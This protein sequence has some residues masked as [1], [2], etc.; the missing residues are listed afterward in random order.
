M[1]IVDISGYTRFIKHRIISLLHAE[2]I[3]TDLLEVVLEEARFPLQLNKLEGD[4]AFLFAP[5]PAG[6]EISTVFR[7]V[8]LQVSGFFKAFGDK[9]DELCTDA[10]ICPCDACQHLRVLKLK[11]VVHAGEVIIKQVRQFEE[12]AGDE[13]ILIHRLLKNSLK[14]DEYIL[15]PAID[16]Q[17][18]LLTDL[19]GQRP[20]RFSEKYAD[21]GEVPLMAWF[22]SGHANKQECKSKPAVWRAWLGLQ[23][24]WFSRFFR[25]KLHI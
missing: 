16:G 12:L 13:V 15:I 14:A 7:D 18:D 10:S 5:V 25:K 9:R 4:A 6:V 19:N 21:I 20:L 23:A 8:L 22:P 1:V 17:P 3:I 2:Q 11:A 24:K